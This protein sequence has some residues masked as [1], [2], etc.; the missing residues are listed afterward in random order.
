MTIYGIH[1][2]IE[3]MNWLLCIALG[4]DCYMMNV[5]HTNI[6]RRSNAYALIILNFAK[7]LLLLLRLQLLQNYYYHCHCY[8]CYRYYQNYHTTM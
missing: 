1:A 3:L 6:H 5:I 8:Y 2:Y 4:C 7:L